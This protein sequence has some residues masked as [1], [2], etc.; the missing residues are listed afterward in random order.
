MGEAE[1]DDG[2]L[3][4]Q[5]LVGDG[6]AGLIDQLER[7]ADRRRARSRCAGRPAAR[8]SAAS[9]TARLTAKAATMTSGR[10]VRSMHELRP[11]LSHVSEACGRCRRRSSRRTPP[12]RNGTTARPRRAG[13]ACRGPR[14]PRRSRAPPCLRRGRRGH[15]MRS[16]NRLNHAPRDK[17]GSAVRRAQCCAAPSHHKGSIRSRSGRSG[18]ERQRNGPLGDVDEL[19]GLRAAPPGTALAISGS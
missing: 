4:L 18:E 6:L 19:P 17:P 1:E 11:L 16:G 3:A 9:P 10:K 7:A 12:F 13:P 2:R 5:V 15:S 8:T 14:H